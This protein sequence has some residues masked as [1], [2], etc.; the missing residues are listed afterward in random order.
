MSEVRTILVGYDE[1]EVSHRALERGAMLARALGAKLVVTSV[2]PVATSAAARSIGAD[3]VEPGAEHRAELAQARAYLDGE[4][5][6]AEYIEALGHEAESILDA[7]RQRSADLIVVG[8]RE[9]SVVQR[10]LGQSVSDA[11]SHGARCDVLIV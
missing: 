7:G 1:T 9:L 8:A 2:A 6:S 3:P 11:V 4:G 5:L 10:L